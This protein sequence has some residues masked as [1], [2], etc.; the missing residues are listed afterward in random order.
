MVM[1][2]KILEGLA[3]EYGSRSIFSTNGRERVWIEAAEKIAD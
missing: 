2:R 1:K 3:T